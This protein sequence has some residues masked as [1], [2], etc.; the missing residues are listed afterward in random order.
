MN[1]PMPPFQSR[2]TGARRIAWQTSAGVSAT[3]SPR[4][5][6]A[7]RAVSSIDFALRE[8]TPPP[9]ESSAGS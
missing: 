3:A 4:A 8:N 2:S 6:R 7:P 1:V 9:G 5:P